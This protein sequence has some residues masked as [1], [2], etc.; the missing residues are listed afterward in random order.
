MGWK[1]LEERKRRDG[2]LTHEFAQNCR[3]GRESVSGLILLDFEV[4]VDGTSVLNVLR[5]LYM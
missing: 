1:K 5:Y 4:A 2:G 3:N